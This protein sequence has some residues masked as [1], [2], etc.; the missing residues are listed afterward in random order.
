MSK[1]YRNRSAKRHR[2]STKKV[3]VRYFVEVDDWDEE[4]PEVKFGQ[5]RVNFFQAMYYKTQKY[6]RCHY[7]CFECENVFF[8]LSKNKNKADCPNCSE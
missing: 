8:A 4:H 7:Y 6:H 5:E 1:T 2:A 3:W